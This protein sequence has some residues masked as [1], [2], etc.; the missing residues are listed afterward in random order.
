LI[1]FI[2]YFGLMIALGGVGR[3]TGD[4]A[5]SQPAGGAIG[6][7]Q[8]AAPSAKSGRMLSTE[9]AMDSIAEPGG[10]AIA[11][12]AADVADKKIIKTGNLSLKVEKADAAA[13]G[14]ANIAK[15]NN[16]EVANSSFSESNRGIK[17]GYITVR[18]PFQNF[19]AVFNEIKKIATQVISESA[20][21]QDITE[22]YIDL[23]ARLKNKR[24]EEASFVAL[25]NRSGKI[26]EIL[27]VTREVARTRG[28]IEQLDG[29]LR[30]LNS[31]TDMSAITVNLSEDV[32][33]ASASVDWRPWQVIKTS[34]KQLI[35]GGQNFVDGLI[36]FII[37]ALPMLLLY[38]LII[39]LIY[40]IGKKI[41][42]RF[43]KPGQ[44]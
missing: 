37:I 29:R 39:W 14:I 12:I 40:Y 13:E 6:M 23:E 7:F 26:E 36:R 30:Y 24:A 9:I 38:G 10:G 11:N 19:T 1:F 2:L 18:V 8:S 3:I 4:K 5:S 35:T 16:G 42:N 27:A 15:L 21:A 22:E 31:Q 28:E 17:S 43:N 32:E 20:N 44:Q 25:L 33:I 41:Y 34:V